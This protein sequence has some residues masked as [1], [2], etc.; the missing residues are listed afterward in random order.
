[1]IGLLQDA[2]QLVQ[3]E[4]GK[5]RIIGLRLGHVLA[6]VQPGAQHQPDRPHGGQP[7]VELLGAQG[8]GAAAGPRVSSAWRWWFSRT[9][10]TSWRY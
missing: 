4:L 2:Q 10:P 6:H 5:A 1:M 3:G 7:P 9:P 8:L